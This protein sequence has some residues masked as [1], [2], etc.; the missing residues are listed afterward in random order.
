[1]TIEFNDY[2]RYNN[3]GS[4]FKNTDFKI[5]SISPSTNFSK[6]NVDVDLGF[7]FYLTSD[8][9]PM[10]LFPKLKATKELVKDV[11]L[12]YGGLDHNQRKNTL[13]SLSDENPYIHSYGM[14]QSI[15]GDSS[16]LQDLKVTDIHELYFGMRNVLGSGEVVEGR[17][18]YGIVKN[19]E[20]FILINHQNYSRFRALY[21]DVNVKQFNANVRYSKEIN[22]IISI[23]ANADYLSWDED[24]YHRSDLNANL[25]V[26]INLRDKIKLTPSIKYIGKKRVMD[27]DISKI[28]AQ[29]HVDLSLYYAYSKQL[30]AYLNLN[31]LTNTTEDLWLGYRGIG[32]NGLFGVS[33]SF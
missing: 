14:N 33:F 16:F 19:F 28:P 30:S 32:F 20:H 23:H 5:F 27:K 13:K 11:L 17:I 10:A 21:F 12:I 29:I 24:V 18:A 8:D 2:L 25:N 3:S 22:N 26:L 15:L 4:E 9:S 1:M 31:N 6:Y 7:D